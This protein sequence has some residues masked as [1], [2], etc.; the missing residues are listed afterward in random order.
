V[1]SGLI[2]RSSRNRR[3]VTGGPSSLSQ[4]PALLGLHLETHYCAMP[5]SGASACND[6]CRVGRAAA[7]GRCPPFRRSPCATVLCPAHAAAL[8]VETGHLSPARRAGPCEAPCH[9]RDSTSRSCRPRLPGHPPVRHHRVKSH[10]GVSVCNDRSHI[11]RVASLG[12]SPPIR[13]S[14]DATAAYPAYAAALKEGAWGSASSAFWSS[15]VTA[16]CAQARYR[17]CGLRGAT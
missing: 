15:S 7:L 12:D 8:E 17:D 11:S 10:S 5:Q 6:T 13:R 16:K 3:A 14:S 9:I 1:P 2:A 4:Q